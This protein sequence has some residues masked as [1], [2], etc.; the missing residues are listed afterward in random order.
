MLL[1]L[2]LLYS[3]F[4]KMKAGELVCRSHPI[5]SLGLEVSGQEQST[6]ELRLF[7]CCWRE[8]VGRTTLETLQFHVNWCQLR[9]KEA[10]GDLEEMGSLGIMYLELMLNAIG[11]ASRLV[12]GGHQALEEA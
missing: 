11:D 2:E 5:S 1:H 9:T 7:D 4:L 10:T 8:M 3:C 12:G 6:G